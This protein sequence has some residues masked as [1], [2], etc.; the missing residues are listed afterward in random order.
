MVTPG[1]RRNF[2]T[3]FPCHSEAWRRIQHDIRM[4]DRTIGFFARPQN[5]RLK[6]SC[7]VQGRIYG[8]NYDAMG[9][10]VDSS[11]LMNGVFVELA[12]VA[13]VVASNSKRHVG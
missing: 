1:G 2:P 11:L 6:V 13:L 4:G 9:A 8:W 7:A 12:L 10:R 3:N 5:D